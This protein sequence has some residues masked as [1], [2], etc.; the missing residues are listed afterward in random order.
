[1]RV[2]IGTDVHPVQSGRHC[3]IAGLHWPGLPGCAGHSDGDV[4]AH[5]L[6]DAALSAA[7]ENG[8]TRVKC[9]ILPDN[10]GIRRLLCSLGLPVTRGHD[11]G[12]EC[13]TID[14]SALGTGRKATP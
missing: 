6:C 9:H 10:Q 12:K 3:W 4:A 7:A 2:G 11:D 13:W 1:M 14:A 8:L 5:A